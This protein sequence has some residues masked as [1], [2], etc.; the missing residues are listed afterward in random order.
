VGKRRRCVGVSVAHMDM[1][2]DTFFF[3][4]HALSAVDRRYW[5]RNA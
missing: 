5:K 1:R 3:H 2:Y 4:F